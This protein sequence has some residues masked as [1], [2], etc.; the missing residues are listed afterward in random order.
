MVQRLDTLQEIVVR[1]AGPQPGGE[2]Q[3]EGEREVP[4]KVVCELGFAVCKI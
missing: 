2:P 3:P 1:E 4:G